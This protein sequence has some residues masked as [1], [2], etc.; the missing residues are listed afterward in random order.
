[1][2][3]GKTGME[4]LGPKAGAGLADG[5]GFPCHDPGEHKGGTGAGPGAPPF[6]EIRD[7]GVSYGR[8]DILKGVSAVIPERRQ[9][10]I[11]GP[12]G[13]GKSTLVLALLGE[14]PHTGSITFRKPKPVIG[15]VPQRLDFDR[16]L[17]LSVA[18]F[19]ALGRGFWPLWLRIPKKVNDRNREYLEMVRAGNLLPRP[20]GSLSGGET[21]RVFL[22][23]AL[24]GNPDML[25]LDEPATGVD[26]YGEKLLC[27]ILDTFKRD[28]T[29]VMVSHDLAT[30]KAHGDWIICLNRTVVAQGAPDA[31]FRTDVL[32]RAFGLH[33]GPLFERESQG[34]AAPG[35]A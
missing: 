22:A 14:V 17:P 12:N 31:I 15:Y 24:M 20:L 23:R 18:E 5:G 32:S 3:E 10:V 6:A 26:V 4:P 35:A 8:Y 1:M 16:H 25:I 13:A 9:T 7:L 33:L 27:E 11:I 21:Q 30:A 2:E 28:F 29:I 34:A 19:M